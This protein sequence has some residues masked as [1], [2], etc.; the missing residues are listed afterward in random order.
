RTVLEAHDQAVD[1]DRHIVIL[2]AVQY[3]R[4]GELDDVTIDICAHEALPSRR[5]EE[6][7]E[8]ALSPANQR[9][10]H[11]D[12][13]TLRPRQDDVGNLARR[14][15]RHRASTIRTMGCPT[16]RVEQTQVIVDLRHRAN[17]RPRIRAG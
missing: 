3:R 11:F 10:Q 1:Y 13:L 9:R 16:A 17:R 2:P 4:V 8:L 7:A 15:S 12:T 6:V 5:L 14:L